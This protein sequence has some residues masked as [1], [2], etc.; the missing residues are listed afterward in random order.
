[1]PSR[2]TL[3]QLEYFVAVGDIGS[4]ALASKKINVSPPSIS[5][6]IGQLED[7][8]GLQLFIRKHAQGLSL[9]Q[10]GRQFMPRARSLLIQADALNR[11]ASEISGDVRGP[12]A[13]GCLLTFAQFVLPRLRRSFEDQ[14][15]D[16]MVTQAELDQ[17]EIFTA[18][19]AGEIDIAL[20]YDLEIAQDLI[21]LPL[22]DLPPYA[23][24]S[25]THPLADVPSV[26]VSDLREHPMVLLDLP[27]SN[28]YFLSFFTAAGIKPN[29]RER[30][31]DMAVMRSLVGNGY[32]YGIANFQPLSDESPDGTR[33]RFIPLAGNVRA[34]QMGL[35]M[36]NGA[37]N[38]LIVKVFIEHCRKLITKETV[39]GLRMPAVG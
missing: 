3:R 25:E 12:L 14:Y 27:L 38:V 31:R 36:A 37:E 22:V 11:L 29:I 30:S 35:L 4:I 32:G 33:L 28:D 20:T 16:V 24:V 10:A 13:L 7:E 5:A 2:F 19:R 15:G 17:Q 1:M 39:P 9:T 18:L 34:M 8:F 6:A 26:T 21:F 23:M